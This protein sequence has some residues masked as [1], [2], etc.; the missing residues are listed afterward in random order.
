MH[1]QAKPRV[2]GN[3]RS[4]TGDTEWTLPQ[5]LQRKPARQHRDC[6]LV[7]SGIVRKLLSVVYIPRSVALN[8]WPQQTNTEMQLSDAWQT[9]PGPFHWKKK[10]PPE[11]GPGRYM[12]VRGQACPLKLV[13]SQLA[14]PHLVLLSLPSFLVH[15]PSFEAPSLFCTTFR[16]SRW[17]RTEAPGTR[18][19]HSQPILW[20]TDGSQQSGRL[21][22]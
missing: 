14:I 19:D 20:R 2:A 5:S 12:A 3:H 10:W 6:R 15:P 1:P 13:F 16:P 17:P 22:F 7:A 11:R 18:L 21:R 4:H 9:C 8:R